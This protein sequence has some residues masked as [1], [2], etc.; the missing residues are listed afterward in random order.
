[1]MRLTSLLNSLNGGW[2]LIE[3]P[4]F[5]NAMSAETNTN[6]ANTVTRVLEATRQLN[7]VIGSDPYLGSKLPL[8]LQQHNFHSINT[9]VNTALFQGRSLQAKIWRLALESIRPRL[10]E[11]KLCSS[12]D[13]EKFIQLTNDPTNWMLDYSI[14]SV[15]GQ[16][17][18]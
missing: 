6:R 9:A 16:K 4:D 5:T 3:E 15:W 12:T 2:L 17:P 18:K 1:M 8:I 7:E 13:I 10:L 14:M 11:L